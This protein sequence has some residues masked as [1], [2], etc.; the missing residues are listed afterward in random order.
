MSGG[1]GSLGGTGG[2]PGTGG[3][4]GAGGDPG[5]G[6][7]VLKGYWVWE[8]RVSGTTSLG[9]AHLNGQAMMR[10][11][12][13]TGNNK[14]QY[15]WNETTGSDFHTDESR[16]VACPDRCVPRAIHPCTLGPDRSHR[17]STGQSNLVQRSENSYLPA[18]A[19]L[20][21]SVLQHLAAN[22]EP[23]P[24]TTRNP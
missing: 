3:T 13:G 14:C 7:D 16:G 22:H 9:F 5:T 12:F 11:A 8:D 15:I 20:A 21:Q 18:E 2:D 4:S 17:V 6:I 19:A 10:M 24:R 1:G 23:L